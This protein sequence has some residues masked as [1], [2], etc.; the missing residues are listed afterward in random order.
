MCAK[1]VHFQEAARMRALR[2]RLAEHRDVDLLL[3]LGVL[4]PRSETRELLPTLRRH[5]ADT[6]AAL[7]ERHKVR[8]VVAERLGAGGDELQSLGEALQPAVA[9]MARR[10]RKVDEVLELLKTVGREADA[11]IGLIKGLSGR[12]L[13]D[14]PRQRDIG[15]F[16]IY[17]ATAGEA[18]RCAVALLERGFDFHSG[19]PPWFKREETGITYGQV[20]LGRPEEKLWIDFHFGCYSVRN[21]AQ[22]EVSIP[23]GGGP[24]RS[25]ENVPMLVANAAGDCFTTVKDLNDLYLAATCREVDWDEARRRILS[26]RLEGYFNGMLKQLEALFDLGDRRAAVREL[27]FP[28]A[29]EPRPSLLR[30]SWMKRCFLTT[31]HT[32]R[33]TAGTPLRRRGAITREA[34]RYY[35]RPLTT[36]LV[37]GTTSAVQLRPEVLKP[38]ICVRAIPLETLEL[39]RQSPRQAND[40]SARRGWRITSDVEVVSPNGTDILVVGDRALIPTV[41]GS[42]SERQADAAFAIEAD[43]SLKPR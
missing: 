31:W 30:L 29:Y 43:R 38:W 41:Y 2:I 3:Q 19:E 17:V 1:G 23:P 16:D 21:C 35:R 18:W 26:A 32:W 11:D 15:D 14:D 27:R 10:H 24:V 20:R 22:L 4:A 36:R 34:W 37:A 9:A 42:I 8:T 5:G 25:E 40:A 7:Y 12:Q 33:V 39:S 28:K 6:L 13:Y